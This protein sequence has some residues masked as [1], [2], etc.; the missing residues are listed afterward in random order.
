[1]SSYKSKHSDPIRENKNPNVVMCIDFSDN[2]E[3]RELIRLMNQNEAPVIFCE[4]LAGT[5]K[6]FT[7]VAAALDLVIFKKKYS[8]IYYIR[9]PVEVGHSIGF[10]PGELEDKYGVYLD[11]LQDNIDHIHEF[12]QLPVNALKDKIECVPPEFVRGRSFENAIIIADEAQNFT[13]TTIQTLMTRLGKYCKI[14]FLGST[15]QIDVKGFTKENNDFMKSYAI[16]KDTGLVSYVQLKKSERSAASAI[17]DEAFA[18]YED[19]K[20]DQ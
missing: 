7:A 9:E 10:L 18:K 13:L 4:G 12:C 2:K 8:K 1:M 20:V 5:G 6:T 17:L 19:K 14:V 11:G 3:Q 15:N 16:V